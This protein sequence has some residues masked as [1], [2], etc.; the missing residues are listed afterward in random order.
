MIPFNFNPSR[1]LLFATL[2]LTIA[3]SIGCRS[4]K[5]TRDA[6][7]LPPLASSPSAELAAGSVPLPS[8]R[9][10]CIE[11]A[12]SVAKSGHAKEAIKLYERAEEL[13][14]DAEPLDT[15]LAPLYVQVGN[16]DAAITRYKRAT[17]RSPDDAELSNNY[18]WTLMETGRLD[19]AI[20]E[21]NRG[22]ERHPGDLRLRS[23]LAVIH[24]HHGDRAKAM[25]HFEKGYGAGA[26]HHNLAVL[27][28]DAG[29]LDSARNHLRLAL[30]TEDP[31][32]Q[33]ETM[34]AAL[35]SGLMDR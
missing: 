19:R 11:T 25:E 10:L 2:L 28:I 17:Q 21:A 27:D 1:P 7:L 22:L 4:F 30:Q 29:K 34:L 20:A 8:D 26:A 6:E 24:Y 13:E 14:P 5:K 31:E 33:T 15:Q 23:T 9:V 18:A 3:P 16:H 12:H 32:S 35:D